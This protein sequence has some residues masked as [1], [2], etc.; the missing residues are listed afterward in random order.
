MI[1]P[2][3][4]GNKYPDLLLTGDNLAYF[5]KNSFIEVFLRYV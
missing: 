2:S 3:K 4:T 1:K 5:I